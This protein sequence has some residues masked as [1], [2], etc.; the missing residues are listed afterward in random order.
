M[1]KVQSGPA[2]GLLANPFR[3]WKASIIRHMTNGDDIQVVAA[4]G[5][6]EHDDLVKLSEKQF[7]SLST[8]PTT[9]EE[10]VAAEPAI[11]TGSDVRFRDPDSD[12]VNFAVA[13]KGASWT[14]PD[15]IPL[16]VMQSLIGGW[17]SDNTNGGVL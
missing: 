7:S 15:A 3:S 6:V 17:N 1:F 11:F 2:P 16:M 5:A 10:L 8:D 12:V 4:A 14:D 13:F 9:S